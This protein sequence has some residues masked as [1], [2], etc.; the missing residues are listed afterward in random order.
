LARGNGKGDRDGNGDGE[1]KIDGEGK[2][3]GNGS[4][5]CLTIRGVSGLCTER[6]VEGTLAGAAG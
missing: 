3:E 1:G 5:T 4:P 6:I 2:G